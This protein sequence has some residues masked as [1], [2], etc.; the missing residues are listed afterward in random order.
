[1]SRTWRG[2][3]RNTLSNRAALSPCRGGTLSF[4]FGISSVGAFGVFEASLDLVSDREPVVSAAILVFQHTLVPPASRAH[5]FLSMHLVD[6]VRPCFG[7]S[8]LHLA[9][10]VFLFGNGTQWHEVGVGAGATSLIPGMGYTN[11]A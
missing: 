9:I 7:N 4:S 1:M 6:I 5:Y 3:Q 10:G 11:A 8:V 2:L